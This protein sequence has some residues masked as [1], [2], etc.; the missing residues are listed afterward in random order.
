MCCGGRVGKIHNKTVCLF[1]DS[2]SPFKEFMQRVFLQQLEIVKKVI[3]CSIVYNCSLL[4]TI[5][6]AMSWMSDRASMQLEYCAAKHGMTRWRK[7]NLSSLPLSHVQEVENT[8][9]LMKEKGYVKIHVH[10]LI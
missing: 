1:F 2:A 10:M 3:Y 8:I 9:H 4:E 7:R 5:S 6:M